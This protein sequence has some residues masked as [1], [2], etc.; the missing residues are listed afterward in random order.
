[1]LNYQRVS[2][3]IGSIR[4]PK[5]F[6][7]HKW[8]DIVLN[9]DIEFEENMRVNACYI[10]LKIRPPN[11]QRK[12]VAKSNHSWTPSNPIKSSLNL[13]NPHQIRM[14]FRDILPP[15]TTFRVVCPPKS[16]VVRPRLCAAMVSLWS[17]WLGL[18]AKGIQP[19]YDRWIYEWNVL[20]CLIYPWT[21]GNITN[22]TFCFG[23]SDGIRLLYNMRN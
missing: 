8:N 13:I 17:S 9:N 7:C 6:H 5:N 3:L 15:C 16:P 12:R 10:F 23:V 19:E 22:Y 14:K 20:K 4:H 18:Q 2:R 21:D 11:P 1:M